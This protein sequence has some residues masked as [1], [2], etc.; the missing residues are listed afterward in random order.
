MNGYEM[1]RRM[2][3]ARVEADGW[4]KRAKRAEAEVRRLRER[5]TAHSIKRQAAERDAAEL[6]RA[7]RALLNALDLHVDLPHGEPWRAYHDL[8]DTLEAHSK[9]TAR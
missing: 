8:E 9:E 2:T 4:H 3:D 5:R 1:A 7:G 6:R